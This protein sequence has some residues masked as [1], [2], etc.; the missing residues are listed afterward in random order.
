MPPML[1]M[2]VLV[3]MLMLALVMM[4]NTPLWSPSHVSASCMLHPL[5]VTSLSCSPSPPC[6]TRMRRHA[7]CL[8]CFPSPPRC[9]TGLWLPGR[10]HAAGNA[11]ELLPQ[12]RHQD[13]HHGRHRRP[14]Q[15]RQE[16]AHQ[17]TQALTRSAGAAWH[18]SAQG[19]S[20][21]SVY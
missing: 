4:M 10:R 20:A 15:R 13:S 3:L 2:L 12:C 11:Q 5:H 19:G 17:L 1:L 7:A 14:A 16:L 21:Q 6:H 18:I 8:L 9:W